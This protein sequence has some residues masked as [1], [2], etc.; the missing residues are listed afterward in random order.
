MIGRVQFA[1]ARFATLNIASTGPKA[2][3]S[4]ESVGDREVN[5][6]VR[7][8]SSLAITSTDRRSLS[9]PDYA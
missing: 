3:T 7:R 1:V 8:S 9:V 6:G 4:L 5:G 2:K